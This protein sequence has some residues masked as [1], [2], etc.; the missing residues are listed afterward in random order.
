M[1]RWRSIF[2]PLR[3]GVDWSLLLFFVGLFVVLKGVDVSGL[4][5]EAK[6][7][8][9][10][11][12]DG[13]VKRQE[14]EA[15]TTRRTP[16]ARLLSPKKTNEGALAGL[17]AGVLASLLVQHFFFSGLA[18]K[19]VAAAALLVAELLAAAPRVKV[20]VT[21]RLALRLQGEHVFSV[22]PL[23]LDGPVLSIRRFGR[24]RLTDRD[25]P[26]AGEVD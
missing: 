17:A 18:L 11:K 22:P 24:E 25:L 7:A 2:D 13:I 12:L 21:S 15:K 9:V 23:A 5:L 16:F 8:Y 19:H 14:E 4:M 3:S 1:I 20:L 10:A 6:A 26:H